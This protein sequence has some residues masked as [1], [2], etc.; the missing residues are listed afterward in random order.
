MPELK[1]EGSFRN[2]ISKPSNLKY[3]NDILEFELERGSY[4]TVLIDALI[5]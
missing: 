3:K 5:S 4:A 2:L 1:S